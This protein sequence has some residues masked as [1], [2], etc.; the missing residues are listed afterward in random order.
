MFQSA[1]AVEPSRKLTIARI[2]YCVFAAIPL[3]VFFRFLLDPGQTK[4]ERTSDF[5]QGMLMFMV[6]IPIVIVGIGILILQK[7][8][9]QPLR[10]WLI[11]VLFAALPILLS[12]LAMIFTSVSGIHIRPIT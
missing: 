1:D 2:T 12:I 6:N 4:E 11:A 7:I 10:F 3:L 8:K 5:Y 9:R